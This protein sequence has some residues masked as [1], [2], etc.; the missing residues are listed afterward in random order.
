MIDDSHGF[1]NEIQH[2]L[3]TLNK[4]ITVAVMG[5]SV[6]GPGEAHNADYAVTGNGRK[7]FLYVHGQLIETIEDE[8]EA[9]E[10]LFSL[11]NG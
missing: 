5:C 9:E 1:L 7:I 10:K 3:L 11:L 2:R 8:R 4:D 6:N